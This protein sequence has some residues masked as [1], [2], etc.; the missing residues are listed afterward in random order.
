MVLLRQLL[1]TKSYKVIAA[2]V[3]ELR[4]RL[5][6]FTNAGELL[7]K[8]ANDGHG[9]ARLETVA[10]TSWLDNEHTLDILHIVGQHPI[11]KWAKSAF[12]H[13]INNASG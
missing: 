6:L 1:N 10:A 13:A 3:R 5:D 4:H 2:A 9:R 7:K 12:I 8:S 11:D